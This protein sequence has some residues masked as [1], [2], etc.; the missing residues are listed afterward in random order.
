MTYRIE[1]HGIFAAGRMGLVAAGGL[2]LL[3]AC[4]TSSPI[5][6][7]A[8]T[9]QPVA[10]TP[11]PPPA[12]PGDIAAATEPQVTESAMLPVDEPASPLAGGD[13]ANGLAAESRV[14]ARPLAG[15]S[16]VEPVTSDRTSPPPA[17][18]AR[19]TGEFP[20]LNV[21]PG[22]A[23]EQLTPEEKAASLAELKARQQ[24]VTATAE[25]LKPADEQER[26]RALGETHGANAL[27]VIE[28]SE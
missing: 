4:S 26:L 14:V 11:L 27:K 2:L 19:D 9:A 10:T 1:R 17:G 13:G 8:P 24:R 15:A 3:A 23:A 12:R 20:N 6:S 16:T 7:L 21:T 5:E 18:A 25:R 28:G 22:T